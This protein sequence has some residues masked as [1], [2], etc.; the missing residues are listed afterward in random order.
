ML[1][2]IRPRGTQI[3]AMQDAY[4]VLPRPLPAGVYPRVIPNP[5]RGMGFA[6]ASVVIAAVWSLIPLS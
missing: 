4:Y 5:K 3:H 1:D 6:L 2:I